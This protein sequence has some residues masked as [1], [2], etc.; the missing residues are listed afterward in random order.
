MGSSRTATSDTDA[1]VLTFV[2]AVSHPPSQ[3]LAKVVGQ[4]ITANRS[5]GIRLDQ[6]DVDADGKLARE[7]G[8][9]SYPAVILTVGGVERARLVGPQSRRAVL[10]AVLPELYGPD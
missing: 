9:L 4:V 6:I 10:H 7:L 2:S 8:V 1:P 3:Q 5:R